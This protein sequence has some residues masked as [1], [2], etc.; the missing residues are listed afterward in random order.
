MYQFLIRHD[1]LYITEI[2]LA[3]SSLNSLHTYILRNATSQFVWQGKNS[4]PQSKQIAKNITPSIF[5]SES[6][7]ENTLLEEGNESPSFWKLLNLEDKNLAKHTQPE[8]VND[9]PVRLY[10]FTTGSGIVEVRLTQSIF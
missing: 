5:S 7:S 2:D 3:V 6:T 1:C 4:P 10:Q 9:K 8:D